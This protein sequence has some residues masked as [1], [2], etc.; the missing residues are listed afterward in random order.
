MESALLVDGGQTVVYQGLR[1]APDLRG[2]G[3]AG[4]LKKHVNAYIRRH[5][6]EVSVVR[7]SRGDQ[8]SPQVLAKYRLIAKEVCLLPQYIFGTKVSFGTEF[9]PQKENSHVMAWT[10]FFDDG[11]VRLRI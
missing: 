9:G 11:R 2:R 5:Y 8:P 7:R 6:P 1:V 3:I 4:T 10:C